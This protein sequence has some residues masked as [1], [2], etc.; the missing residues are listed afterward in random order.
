MADIGRRLGREVLVVDGAMGTMLQRAGIPAEQCPEQLN[1]TAPDIIE[2]LHR[3]YVIAGADCV[4]T[5]TFGGTRAK[6]DEYGLGDQVVELNRAAVRIARR[7]GALHVLAD[8]GPTGL[9]MQPLGAAAFDEVHALFAEQIEALAAEAPDAIIIETMTDIA[10]ARCAVLAARAVCDL[11]VIASV[12]F[13]HDGRMSLSGTD[14]ATAAVV[15]EA[16]G[17]T[18]VGM[19]CGLGPAQ[20]LPLAEAMATT[21]TLPL[22]VQPN[23]GLPTLRDGVTVFPGT[24]DEM[25]LA[26]ASFVDLG[27]TLVGSCCGSSPSFTGAIS[28]FAKDRPLPA[29]RERR[30]G[31]VLAG[32]RGIAR[33]GGGER[34]A[35]IGERINPTGKKALAESLR[36]GSMAIVR[37]YAIEQQQSGAHLLDVNVGAPGV[38]AA[39]AL[40]EVVLA[41][42][43][44]AEVPLVL[45][46]TDPAA[47][48]AALKAYPGRA[49]INSVNGGESSMATVLPLA[50]RYGA[51]VVVLALDDDGI[52]VTV[53]GRV[54]IVQRVRGH[55]HAA[56]LAD[57]DLIVDCLTLTAASDPHAARVAVDAVRAVSGT[58]GLAT[59][60]GVSNVSHGL[61]GR[62]ALN[63]AFLAMAAGAGL[64]AAIINPADADAMRAVAAVDVLL[65]RDERAERWIEMVTTAGTPVPEASA[66][67]SAGSGISGVGASGAED[68]FARVETTPPAPTDPAIRLA[69]AVE[70]GDADGAPALVEAIITAGA[71]PQS[72]I[73]DVLTP[74]IQRLGDA[75]GRGEAFLPQLIAAAGAMKAA[76]DTAKARL[77]EGERAAEGRVVFG[78]VKGDIH[79][80]G[81]DICISMLE[82]Q[83]FA[84]DDLGVDVAPERF[85]DAAA[86]ADVVCLSALMT[87]TLPAMAA[88]ASALAERAVPVLVGGAVVTADYALSI[89]A[90]YSSDAPGCVAAVRDVVQSGRNA[91]PG[92]TR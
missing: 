49:L 12:T 91:A 52:P 53:E 72:V 33:I 11:P 13:G 87:T 37:R 79:S 32:P 80:I 47:L 76:V 66:R 61:P 34:F 54:S 17:A 16:A 78:T 5:N 31:V 74:A 30:S 14:P 39:A 86:D 35:V 27:A 22:V 36:A 45:D 50:A 88:T 83:G 62:P 21:T 46:T 57:H 6:L 4:S 23:A 8:V 44:L 73:A 63:A 77:P 43:G 70:R 42:V 81:K 18:V 28:D 3:N 29:P 40:P 82:S 1:V 69:T 56:G 89:G 9:V 38:D 58:L 75:Y 48:E 68:R 26:A 55:A 84:V 20:L 60:L 65:G 15:L 59:V 7:S 92:D 25:G 85:I 67:P 71:A 2:D 64:D 10:E 19:N 90:G 51:A 24:P 41:L